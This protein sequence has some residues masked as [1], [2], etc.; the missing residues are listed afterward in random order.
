MP[1]TPS[2]PKMTRNETVICL[3]TLKAAYP[4]FYS[5]QSR[6]ELEVVLNLWMLAFEKYDSQIVSFALLEL[7]KTHTG[8][9]PDIAA[10]TSKVKEIINA[11]NNEPTDEE[12]FLMLRESCSVYN[13]SENF[14]K[15]PR[16]L[17]IFCGSPN[18]LREFGQMDESTFNTVIH[19]QFLRTIESIRSKAEID[20]N[21]PESVKALTAKYRMPDAIEEPSEEDKARRIGDRKNQVLKYLD[22]PVSTIPP[23][24]YEPKSEEEIARRKKKML[25][26]LNGKKTD[27]E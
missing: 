6:E 22:D 18:R 7:I 21:I 17:Q 3:S 12:L 13:A 24:K 25:E 8:Y 19:G 14:K 5:K 26:V 9:P 4:A 16:V 20:A 23:R 10:L 2:F 27:T 11:G 1:P 15:L